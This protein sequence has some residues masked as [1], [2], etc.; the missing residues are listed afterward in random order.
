MTI[1]EV[2]LHPS[3]YS[4]KYQP[5]FHF[6]SN[7][8]YFKNENVVDRDEEGGSSKESLVRRVALAVRV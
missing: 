1:I 4:N 5:G 6:G 3:L 2:F 7:Q 8:N